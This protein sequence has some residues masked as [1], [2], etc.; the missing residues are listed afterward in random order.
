MLYKIK[1]KSV[2]GA[3]SVVTKY[4]KI[5]QTSEVKYLEFFFIH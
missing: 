5:T 2:N 4:R 1:T 3:Y